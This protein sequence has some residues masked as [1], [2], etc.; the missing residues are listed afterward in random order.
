MELNIVISQRDLSFKIDNQSGDNLSELIK[1]SSD[2]KIDSIIVSG[3]SSSYTF[4]RQIA[5]FVNLSSRLNVCE[6]DVRSK[7]FS[8]NK[9][10]IAPIYK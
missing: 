10:T 6:V 2:K 8:K 9:S 3:E 1:V 5:L 4:L 7:C